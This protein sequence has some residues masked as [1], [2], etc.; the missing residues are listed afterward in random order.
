[1]KVLFQPRIQNFLATAGG[2]LKRQVQKTKEFLEKE[3]VE[4]TISLRHD[5]NLSRYDLVHLFSPDVYYQ[6]LNTRKHRTPV[7]LSTIYWV[8]QYK[9]A[10]LKS[11]IKSN[12]LL[13]GRIMKAALASCKQ[14]E[15]GRELFRQHVA[16]LTIDG[17]RQHL[18]VLE[19]AD[20][21]LP[22]GIDEYNKIVA[23]TGLNKNYRVIPNAVDE[24][25]IYMEETPV[26]LP[27]GEFALCVAAI[28]PR[29][30]QLKLI[31]IANEMG[32][33]LVLA[34][35]YRKG[36]DGYFEQCQQAARSNTVFLG[37]LS[38]SQLVYVYRRAKIHVLASIYE[39][40]GL[41]SLE[42]ALFGCPI[43]S[44]SIGAVYEYF[45]DEALYCDPYDYD[46]IRDS[47]AS[48]WAAPRNETLKARVL[49]NYTWKTVAEMTLTA[50]RELLETGR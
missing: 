10:K 29:K 48:A 1:M 34:G 30:N 2:G 23:N 19:S 50:Y 26:N 47:V 8:D 40:P 14:G 27:D 37:E 45:G 42:A 43:V 31:Q 39:T 36:V 18:A 41:S 49:N 20:V 13:P 4:V 6:A 16:D 33:N 46:T 44:T 28:T 3:G 11:R 12:I 15:Y 22:N 35:S 5:E 17:L 21:W 9:S 38:D 32:I 25:L 7:V 24:G